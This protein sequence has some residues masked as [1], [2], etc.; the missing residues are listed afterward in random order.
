MD[1]SLVAN[2]VIDEIKR[3]GSSGLLFKVDLKKAYDNIDWSFLDLVMAKMRS[4]VK[5]RKW[6]LACV[7]LRAC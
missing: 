2:E 1:C 7:P 3:N 5:W 4:G 6:I